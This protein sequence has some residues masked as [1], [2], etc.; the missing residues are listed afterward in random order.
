MQ[1]R[2]NTLEAGHDA[3]GKRVEKL[4]TQHDR[5]DRALFGFTDENGAWNDGLVQHVSDIRRFAGIGV[6]LLGRAV[7]AIWAAVSALVIYLARAAW[8]EWTSPHLTH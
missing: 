7:P 4:E 5:H 2:V 1:Q 6:A 3:L 8:I